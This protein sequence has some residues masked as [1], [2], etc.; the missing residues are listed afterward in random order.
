MTRENKKMP[1]ESLA[2]FEF[3]STY[4]LLVDFI[5]ANQDKTLPEIKYQLRNLPNGHA[6]KNKNFFVLNPKGKSFLHKAAAEE[7]LV[8]ITFLK[9]TG[10]IIELLDLR[11]KTPLYDA[12]AQ[13]KLAAANHLLGY[14]ANPNLGNGH[15]K[16]TYKNLDPITNTEI[17]Y[18][19]FG[20]IIPL[21]AAI[22]SKATVTAAE[23]SSVTGEDFSGL[24]TEEATEQAAVRVVKIL[25]E[26]GANINL[27]S[28]R[29]N[30]SALHRAIINLKPL[31]VKELADSGANFR[32][33]DK[34]GQTA[35]HMVVDYRNEEEKQKQ[36]L[37]MQ[38]EKQITE[39][40]IP[41]LEAINIKENL[42]GNTPLHTAVDCSNVDVVTAIY[43]HDYLFPQKKILSIQNKLGDTALHMAVKEAKRGPKVLAILLRVATEDDLAIVNNQRE[44][45]TQL[46][47]RLINEA[48]AVRNLVDEVSAAIEDLESLLGGS[49]EIEQIS[50]S[51]E[52]TQ[53]QEA[54]D[55]LDDHLVHSRASNRLSVQ[56]E[57]LS[58][59]TEEKA[60]TTSLS[61]E[62]VQNLISRAKQIAIDTHKEFFH[63]GYIISL[64][65]VY[66]LEYYAWKNQILQLPSSFPNLDSIDTQSAAYQADFSQA[67]AF[68]NLGERFLAINDNNPARTSIQDAIRI[69]ARLK[70]YVMLER[71][72]QNIAK[73]YINADE[74]VV[75]G[76]ETENQNKLHSHSLDN[77]EK[78]QGHLGLAGLYK[79]LREQNYVSSS[80]LHAD[81]QAYESY[82]YYQAYKLT[83]GD[84]DANAHV[85]L[86]HE[87]GVAYNE[88]LGTYNVQQCV[89]VVAFDPIT[90][91]VV[92]AHFDRYSGP[93]S[94]I[95]KLLKEFPNENKIHLFVMG[96][97]DQAMASLTSTISDNNINQVF[98]Q[99]FAEQ[100]RFEVR[101][102]DVGPGSSPE[103]IVFDPI[104][105]KL[106]HATPNLDDSSLSSR[107]VNFF[108][109]S[110]KAD[111]L[112]PLNVV[113]FTQSATDRTV[114]FTP[115]Q[116]LDILT[117]V[118]T[119]FSTA[120]S[121]HQKFYPFMTIENEIMGSPKDF[122]QGLLKK[123]L[124]DRYQGVSLASNL[125][126][127]ASRRRR[128]TS[129]CELDSQR[130]LEELAELSEAKQSE[131]LQH[132]ATRR[133]GGTQQKE[134]AKLLHNQEITNHLEEVNGI[135]SGLMEGMFYEDA[136]A[137]WLKGNRFPA[138]QLGGLKGLGHVLEKA[139]AKMNAKGLEWIAAG[140]EIRGNFLR[141]GTPFIRRTGGLGFIAYDLYEQIS[142]LKKDSNN[143]AALVGVVSE[144]I[145]IGTDLVA[146]GVE[147]A[148]ITSARF[149]LM[150]ISEVT[151]PL[152]EAVVGIVMLGDKIY[153]AVAKVNDED[154]LLHLS[155]GE[156]WTEGMRAFLNLNSVF[157][158]ELD[159]ITEYDRIL[160]EQLEFL[161]KHP[162]IKHIIFPAIEKVGE[163]AVCRRTRMMQRHC[164][165]VYEPIFSE[166]K[167]NSVYF[168]D[169]LIGFSLTREEITPPEGSELLCVPTAKD[170]KALTDYTYA[171]DGALGLTNT[172]TSTANTAFFNLRDGEDHAVGFEHLTN[173]FLVNDGKKDYVGGPQDDIYIIEA[174][175]VVTVANRDGGIG[176]L[177]AG[178]GSDSLM[179]Q[180][181]RPAAD[182]MEVN[183]A[184]SYLK[185]GNRTLLITSIEK[186]SGGTFPLAVTAAGDTQEIHLAGGPSLRNLD[187]L[188][189]PKNSSSAYDLK[190]YLQPHVS[191][192]NEADVGNFTYYI[193]PGKGIVLVNATQANSNI[194]QQFVF[195]AL[196]SDVSI[197]SFSA[198]SSDNEQVRAIQLHLIKKSDDKNAEDFKFELNA[199]LS[200]TTRL[201]F[202]DN[203]ELKLG[204][205]NLYFFQHD[206]NQS[207]SAIMDKFM[208]IARDLNLICVL[209]TKD[210]EH[211]VIGHHGKEVMHNNPLAR[212]HL[213]GNGGEGVFVIKSG[214]ELLSESQLPIKEVVLY[215]R[216][217]DTHIDSLDFRTLNKQ[218]RALNA[219]AKLRFIA[220]NK[221]NKLGNNL[222][223]VFGMQTQWIPTNKII[224]IVTI[225]LKD[226][227]N[228][229]HKKYLHI[230]LD[231]APQQIVGRHSHLRLKPIPLVFDPQH[232]IASV[233]IKD[234][235][236][237]THLIIPQ[238]YQAGAFFHH[239]KTNLLWTNTLSNSSH[240][241]EPFTLI[242]QNFFQESLLK[243][244]SLQFTNKKIVLKNKLAEIYTVEDFEEAKTSRLASLKEES[245][246][247]MNSKQLALHPTS[248]PTN[249]SDID[250]N[251]EHYSGNDIN[252]T[253]IEDHMDDYDYSGEENEIDLFIRQRRSVEH[254]EERAV[255]DAAAPRHTG[256]LQTTVNIVKSTIKGQSPLE[257]NSQESPQAERT[258]L[259]INYEGTFY[260]N[261]YLGTWMASLFAP[262]AVKRIQKR[263]QVLSQPEKTSDSDWAFK[264]LQEGIK[265]YGRG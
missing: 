84:L 154:H 241:I 260:G 59:D 26:K 149:A 111:Y 219:T 250:I 143:T 18:E 220:A 212:T 47:S 115:G 223:L 225:F 227:Q 10:H 168:A 127:I 230:I 66:Q 229:W 131:I 144:G 171:C 173:I 13:L 148:E 87:M 251:Q 198:L 25:I 125:A 57:G 204:N 56:L 141:A 36:Q 82:H 91:K 157:Q 135:S 74:F 253:S 63:E 236:E 35:L 113:D 179:L 70:N 129:L 214:M 186:L 14:A 101:S 12:C 103:S 6:L 31:I 208:P 263:G 124:L 226:V 139:S 252:A 156:K 191:I 43:K 181:F 5:K 120:S 163:K 261:V 150:G 172:N 29:E 116:Q 11:H 108:L 102:S 184:A 244:L 178:D 67:N 46:A 119:F 128:D 23:L 234:V 176:G 132:V 88:K 245:L 37:Q 265:K 192:N 123:A 33:V 217:E 45:P 262:A 213:H 146:G 109:Q 142:A 77:Q 207:V 30:F 68:F 122:Q 20:E 200:N 73:T 62:D 218:V 112:R 61:L 126:C 257:L 76:Y 133:V 258:S 89:V 221:R 206:L 49:D 64:K 106:V 72:Y 121:D 110:A 81:L 188:L 39:L 264:N 4:Q 54:I 167:D 44:T 194:K 137:G 140:N 83:Q 78:L 55:N 136:L 22:E 117:Y 27:Q 161:K 1:Y 231:V 195:N 243:T 21:I 180:E 19:N 169:K 96:G 34:E 240:V 216:P 48:A 90:K 158:K 233:G 232:E 75:M 177:D 94:F 79:V 24:T 248:Q 69:Y 165:T 183:L 152:G 182:Y 203:A 175:Q 9:E 201:H 197:L 105:K 190:M 2:E 199:N 42:F 238:S 86:Q 164:T 211:I 40:I 215:H 160:P 95:E 85:V 71:C 52:I 239:N 17:E 15:L 51:P 145:Q 155:T 7:N 3:N 196:I 38:K 107:E 50:A 153:A 134:V 259:P 114:S 189:I 58:L 8:L 100:E 193:L 249:T 98:K 97:R 138:I 256:I 242:L 41:H 224:P 104:S 130:L 80:F 254:P 170:G 28:G 209:V 255:T 65:S 237:N 99:I 185:Y 174:Q 205:K 53:L 247:I 235:E 151:G 210:N 147:V 162:E 32:L 187:T 92:L 60:Q 166:V 222:K 93:L 246:A 228:H 202:I 16:Q 118:H 159:E